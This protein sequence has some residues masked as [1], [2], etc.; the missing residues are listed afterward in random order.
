MTK[1]KDFQ[2]RELLPISYIKWSAF[3]RFYINTLFLNNNTLV[4]RYKSGGNIPGIKKQCIS[5]E[6]K[7]V[8]TTLFDT[9]TIDYNIGKTLNEYEKRLFD[10]LM[11]KSGLDI[12]FNYNPKLMDESDADLKKRFQIIQGELIAGNENQELLKEAIE[13][14]KKMSDRNIISTDVAKELIDEIET[15]F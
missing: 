12:E 13:L 11:K 5:E 3:G 2:T 15:D 7:T 10:S 8:I 6:L 1:I 14:L 4:V 9:K